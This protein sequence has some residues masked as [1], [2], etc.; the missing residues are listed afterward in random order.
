MTS[1]PPAFPLRLRDSG[2]RELLRRVAE[3][4]GISQNE[5]VEQALAHELLIRGATIAADLAQATERLVELTDAQ[6]E[7]AV[8]RGLREFGR[9]ESAPEPLQAYAFSRAEAPEVPA[10]P[11]GVLDAFD[12]PLRK[13]GSAETSWSATAQSD[14]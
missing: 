2:L 11:L 12:A 3:H 9:G 8:A 4:D 10:D 7:R 5:L 14:S 13:V 1:S 6:Y